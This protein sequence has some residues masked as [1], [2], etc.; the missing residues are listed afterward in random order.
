MRRVSRAVAGRG[1]AAAR[2]S[3]VAAPAAGLL[4]ALAACAGA[5]VV[6][7]A[8]GIGSPQVASAAGVPEAGPGSPLAADAPADSAFDAYVRGLSDST[9]AWFGVTAAPVDTAGLDSALAARIRLPA[10]ARQGTG[11]R[12]RLSPEFHPAPGFNRADGGQLGAGLALG[13]PVAGRLSGRLQWTT[14]T[15]DLLG[16]AAWTRSWPL[17][18]LRSRGS[19]RLAAG[20][21]TDPVDRDRYEPAF[22][23]MSALLWG[24]DRHHYLRRDGFR[25]SLRIG[26]DRLWGALAWRDELESTLPFTTRWTLFGGGPELDFNEPATFGRARELGFTGELPV[27]GTRFRVQA[28]HWTSDPRLASDFTYRRTLVVAGGDLSLG[29]HFAFVPQ[30]VYGRLRGEALP[31]AAFHLGGTPNLRSLER[32]D[33]AASGLGFVRGELVLVDDLGTLLRLPLPA[34][35][36]LQAGAFAAAGAAWGFEPVTHRVAATRRDW[37]RRSEW[38]AE[39]GGTLAWRAGIPDPLSA[40]R[41]E[42]ALPIGADPREARFTVS[43]AQP[44]ALFRLR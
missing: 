10:G 19:L 2:R 11:G 32:N 25:S 30:A 23:T 36:P 14:G 15:H 22:T 29:R 20:R 1:A 21:W 35:M 39:A 33:R 37:P 41:F 27:P 38:L 7:A 24:G 31:Q 3:V 4:L 42:Y 28:G 44:L 18:G 43:Y 8:A 16:E 12:R 34:W 40:L 9:A 17:R 6:H 5:G 26:N 13:S